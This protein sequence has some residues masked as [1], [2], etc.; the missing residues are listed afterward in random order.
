MYL[1]RYIHNTD[2]REVEWFCSSTFIMERLFY[3]R[4]EAQRRIR[5][6]QRVKFNDNLN[7]CRSCNGQKELPSWGWWGSHGALDSVRTLAGTSCRNQDFF[8]NAKAVGT[9]YPMLRIGKN[10][11]LLEDLLCSSCQVFKWLDE[12]HPRQKGPTAL[13]P[14]H[15]NGTLVQDILFKILRLE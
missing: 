14:L 10:P 4:F 11:L 6:C 8:S 7:H 13:P 12:D 15:F 5:Q 2:M 3:A 1:H 9:P